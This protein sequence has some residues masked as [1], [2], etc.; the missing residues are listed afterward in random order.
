MKKKIII[1]AWVAICITPLAMAMVSN[2]V[3]FMLAA[4]AWTVVF[5]NVSKQV[6]PEWMKRVLNRIVVPEVNNG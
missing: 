1:T 3:L 4:M 2:S 5:Y 6:A